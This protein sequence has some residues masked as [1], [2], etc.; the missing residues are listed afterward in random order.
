MPNFFKKSKPAI[1]FVAEVLGNII[2]SLSALPLGPL[3]HRTLET[4]KIVGL[5]RHR[6]N[7]DAEIELSNE[8]F[9]ELA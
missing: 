3:F 1:R 5:K 6:E 9:S 8:T 7:Y 2:S 4:G